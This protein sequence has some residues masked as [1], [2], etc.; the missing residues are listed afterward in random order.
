MTIIWVD[1]A[2]FNEFGEELFVWQGCEDG[3]I[4]VGPGGGVLLCPTHPCEDGDIINPCCPSGTTAAVTIYW[5]TSTGGLVEGSGGSIGL[6]W[7]AAAN[8]GNGGYVFF[9]VVPGSTN[10]NP[11]GASAACTLVDPDEGAIT[12]EVNVSG[13]T[14]TTE[15]FPCAGPIDVAIT[16]VLQFD[17]ITALDPR[18][19]D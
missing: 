4:V 2:P 10:P 19:S 13:N 16:D 18:L 1:G 12:L 3:G 11:Q 9:D 15:A 5:T 7:D 14:T 17:G 6:A 8:E